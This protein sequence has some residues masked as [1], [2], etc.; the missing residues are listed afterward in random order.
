MAMMI[1][2]I[3]LVIGLCIAI[4]AI[5]LWKEDFGLLMFASFMII[6]SGL[7]MFN[8][9]INEIEVVFS[10]WIAVIWMSIGAYIG[11]RTSIDL[12]KI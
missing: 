2:G 5:G 11:I 10:H 3:Y 12:I 8:Y 6:L 9:G 1:A 7:H 4:V